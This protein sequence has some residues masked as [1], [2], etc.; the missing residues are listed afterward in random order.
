MLCRILCGNNAVADQHLRLRLLALC[1]RFV[2]FSPVMLLFSP[3]HALRGSGAAAAVLTGWPATACL[4]AADY[5][6]SWASW[7]VRVTWRSGALRQGFWL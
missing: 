7:G 3:G 4:P 1:R 5:W 6:D 2:L